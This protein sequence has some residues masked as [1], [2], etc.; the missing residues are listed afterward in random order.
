MSETRPTWHNCLAVQRICAAMIELHKVQSTIHTTDGRTG[1]AAGAAR[2]AIGSFC[3]VPVKCPMGVRSTE[4]GL[5]VQG[6]AMSALWDV[7]SD[8]RKEWMADL[9]VEAGFPRRWEEKCGDDQLRRAFTHWNLL[10][11]QTPPVEEIISAH[12]K[13]NRSAAQM[14]LAG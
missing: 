4:I 2:H 1:R 3:D 13:I 12:M 10:D 6:G 9:M 14:V 7:L 5:G 11:D 8:I